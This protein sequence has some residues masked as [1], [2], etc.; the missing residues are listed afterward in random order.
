[1]AQEEVARGSKVVDQVPTATVITMMLIPKT[2]RVFHRH[3][4]H[5]HSH[6]HFNFHFHFF[7]VVGILWYHIL[8]FSG[9]SGQGDGQTDRSTARSYSGAAW[10]EEEKEDTGMGGARTGSCVRLARLSRH[11]L[12]GIREMF[13][14]QSTRSRESTM[15][16]MQTPGH[17]Q[18]FYN[19]TPGV[20]GKLR[21]LQT[22]FS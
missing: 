4:R 7:K 11:K 18:A 9:W 15:H 20:A 14:E 3:R 16:C 13:G 21:G 17:V 5:F 6:F 22:S 19:A 2:P 1:M 12:P 10:A 8:C